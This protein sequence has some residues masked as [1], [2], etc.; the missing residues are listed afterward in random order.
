MAKEP[1]SL[2]SQAYDLIRERIVYAEYAPGA[3]LGIKELCE[4]LGLGRTPVRESFLRLQQEDLVETRPQSGTYVSKINL[5]FA[6]AARL[7]RETLER[8]MIVGCC[9]KADAA[10]LTRIDAAIRTQEEALAAS[11]KRAFFEA[12]NL[13]HRA[14]FEVAGYSVVWQWLS[15]TNTHFERYRW[16]SANTL[17][18]DPEEVMG[19]HRAMRRAI[20]E[21]DAGYASFLVREHLQK[22]RSDYAKVVAEYPEYF[23]GGADFAR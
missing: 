20:A 15:L 8:E 18:I 5:A 13:M 1:E 7:C 16:L 2:Q 4:D 21:K 6:E 3:K 23:E 22:S 14:F 10:A 9:V 12:D 11:E 17:G 19:Q